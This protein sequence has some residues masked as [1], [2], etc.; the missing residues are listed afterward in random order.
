MREEGTFSRLEAGGS[1]IICLGGT[2]PSQNVGILI[3]EASFHAIFWE[4]NRK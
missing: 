2:L 4:G 3:T 1:H